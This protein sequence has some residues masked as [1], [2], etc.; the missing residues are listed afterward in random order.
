MATRKKSDAAPSTNALAPPSTLAL[1]GMIGLPESIMS[2]MAHLLSSS[3]PSSSYGPQ[4]FL[5][6]QTADAVDSVH[7]STVVPV[8]VYVVLTAS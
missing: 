2:P 5:R 4:Q 7:R 6:I 8:Y 3:G 1:P